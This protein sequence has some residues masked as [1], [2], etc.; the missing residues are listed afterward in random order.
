MRGSYREMHPG[1]SGG[2]TGPEAFAKL[3]GA[4]KEGAGSESGYMRNALGQGTGLAA[5]LPPEVEG[6]LANDKEHHSALDGHSGA[7][8]AGM[9]DSQFGLNTAAT[10]SHSQLANFEHFMWDYHQWEPYFDTEFAGSRIGG[11]T[12]QNALPNQSGPSGIMSASQLL[13]ERANRVQDT[14]LIKGPAEQGTTARS[15][16]M[17]DYTGTQ[18]GMMGLGVYAAYSIMAR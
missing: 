7:Q 12:A 5:S 8:N 11:T 16:L 13:N 18:L 2:T 1:A 6:V 9:L 10:S 14:V 3:V 15:L 17:R 4:A